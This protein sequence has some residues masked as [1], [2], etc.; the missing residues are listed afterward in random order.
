MMID[1]YFSP[2]G[3][4]CAILLCLM[5]AVPASSD[6]TLS[7]DYTLDTN[8]FFVAGSEA[9]TSLEAAGDFFEHILQDTLDDITPYDT[10]WG[11]N[12]WTADFYHPST[13]VFHSINNPTIPADTLVIYVGARDLGATTLG[14]GGPGGYGLST[15]DDL[16]PDM[17][18]TRGEGT[19]Q[20][21]GANEFAP[22]GGVLALDIDSTWN[23]SHQTDPS[24]GENDLYSVILHELCHVLG[25][26]TAASWN[27]LITAG[28][29]TG[30]ESVNEHGGN[31][32]LSGTAHWDYSTNSGIFP[33]EFSQEA[34]MDPDLT[35]GD[36][37]LMTYLDLAGLDDIGWE[38]GPAYPGDAN[39]DWSVDVSDLGVLATNY[40]TS[41]AVWG[42][43]DFNYDGNV[44]VTDLGLLATYYNTSAAAQAVPEPSVLAG[45]LGL[46][47]AGLLIPSR[48]K[49]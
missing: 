11:S 13:G 9:R 3:F 40:N 8:N 30:T 29:F 18:A 41:G 48:R 5:L 37:K 16:W 47:L 43:G 32:P 33:S 22:W 20:G 31:V 6:V 42:E 21:A 44:D 36:R 34:V 27:N 46:S 12:T 10:Q 25:V 49:R 26:G 4:F 38:V 39:G 17:I 14:R 19:T 24:W 45:L 7:F 1:R 35:Q 23:Y 2:T 28:D 15:W